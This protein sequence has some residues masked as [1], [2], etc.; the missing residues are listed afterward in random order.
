MTSNGSSPLARGTLAPG[1]PNPPAIR[2]IPARA[3]N[4]FHG[5][6]LQSSPTA[7]PRSRGEH[8][9]CARFCDRIYGSSPLAR[10]TRFAR[11]ITFLLLRLIPARAGNTRYHPR[12]AR[13]AA[14]HPRSRGEHSPRTLD[15]G[16]ALGSSPLARGTPKLV[17]AAELGARLI[18]ARAGNTQ[19]TDITEYN[20]TAHPRSRGEHAVVEVEAQ[21]DCGSSPLARGT[22]IG[23]NRRRRANRLIPARAGNTP[24]SADVSP[25]GSAHPRS[26]GEHTRLRRCIT[27]GVGSSPLA[28]GTLFAPFGGDAGGRLIPARAGNTVGYGLWLIVFP[29]HPRSRGEHVLTDTTASTTHGSSPLAR[30]TRHDASN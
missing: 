22:Q 27:R 15:Y 12:R 19:Y 17:H 10:G 30:G 28:R 26:R 4:T 20:A 7:H 18:P 2:L 3:G 25:E 14:A 24:D 5:M 29:A 1:T 8:S 11:Y 16:S 6:R 23:R 9:V 21:P 13:P